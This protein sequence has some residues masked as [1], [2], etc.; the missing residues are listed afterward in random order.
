CHTHKYDS[1]TQKEYYQLFAFYNNGDEVTRQVPV[2]PEAWSSYA[3]ANGDA[4]R[5]LLPL[6]KRLDA[7]KAA[8]PARLPEWEKGVQARLAE[9]RRLNQKPVFT[10]L[11]VVKVEAGSKTGFQ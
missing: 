8:L 5:R 2:S 6:Q 1:I 9:A 7:A 3:K 11:D 4:A 10:A